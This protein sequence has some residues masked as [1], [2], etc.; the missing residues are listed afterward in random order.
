MFGE[1][2]AKVIW[3]CAFMWDALF[4]PPEPS[5]RT[6]RGGSSKASMRVRVKNPASSSYSSGRESRGHQSAISEYIKGS[7]MI[8]T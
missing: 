3:K 5:S 7:T 8:K 6:V 1:R 2:S 4:P